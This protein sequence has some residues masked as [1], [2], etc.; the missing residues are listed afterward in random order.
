M[1]TEI[2]QEIFKHEQAI[3]NVE[4]FKDQGTSWVDGL[5]SD[6]T[7]ESPRDLTLKIEYQEHL[8]QKLFVEI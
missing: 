7:K 2:K 8:G 3:D 6:A 1:Q 5:V 4:M